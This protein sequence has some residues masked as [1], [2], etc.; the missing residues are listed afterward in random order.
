MNL[1]KGEESKMIDNSVLGKSKLE[2]D[3]DYK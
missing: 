3:C 2:K 1:F